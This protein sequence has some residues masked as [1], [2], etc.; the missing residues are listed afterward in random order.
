MC[1]FAIRVTYKKSDRLVIFWRKIMKYTDFITPPKGYGNVP[2]YWWNGDKLDK[3]RI[4]WQLE[5]L[6]EMPV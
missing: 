6:A 3:D 5:K 4:A 2:F 1:F